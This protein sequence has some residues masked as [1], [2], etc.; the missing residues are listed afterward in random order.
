[1]KKIFITLFILS[2]VA[3][4]TRERHATATAGIGPT[5]LGVTHKAGLPVAG[6]T[7]WFDATKSGNTNSTWYDSSGNGHTATVAS[8][9]VPTLTPSAINGKSAY[10]FVSAN[11]TRMGTAAFPSNTNVSVFVA[12]KLTN[13]T[14][15]AALIDVSYSA[16]YS[17]EYSSTYGPEFWWAS[18]DYLNYTATD[19]NTHI[20]AMTAKS[21]AGGYVSYLDGIALNTASGG[22]G[23]TT[24][25]IRAIGW[26]S[27]Y[28]AGNTIS[29]YLGEI[30]E[31][32]FVLTTAQFKSVD[33][34]LG[35]KWGVVVP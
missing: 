26:F 6:A 9:T 32:P 15:Y 3:L 30:V 14:P 16:N 29:G 28:G 2:F 13:T 31:Y 10:L 27:S 8:G 34:Y 19:L 5:M 33:E 22:T 12:F 20:M 17:M 21:G 24:S 25:Y 7:V 23:S 35:T 4:L 1:M 18:A 11:N